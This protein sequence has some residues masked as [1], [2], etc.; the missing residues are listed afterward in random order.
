MTDTFR[1]MALGLGAIALASGLVA[2]G[3][4]SAQGQ[5]PDGGPPRGR[6][7]GPPPMGPFG[8]GPGMALGLPMM[9]DQLG[10]SDT[11]KDQLKTLAD[12]QR[13]Y[14]KSLGDRAASARQAL[15]AAVTSSQFDEAT[16]R[17]RAADLGVVE[18]DVAVASARAFAE[19]FQI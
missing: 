4:A 12:S 13:D 2:G 11:Q 7:M 10:L 3:Y 16:I 17:Q 8:M 6:H 5:G 14:W 19:A 15:H 9:G 1:R 18:G